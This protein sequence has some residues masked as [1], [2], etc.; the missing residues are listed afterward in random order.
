VKIDNS[1]EKLGYKIREVQMQKIPYMLVLGDNEVKEEA[2]NVRKY[3]NQQS[4][5]APF[6]DFKKKIV[7]QIKERSI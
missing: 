2:V 5:S 7:Q 4:E 1:N 3:G 6:E